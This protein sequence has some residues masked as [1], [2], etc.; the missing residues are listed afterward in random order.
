M[1]T[2][3]IENKGELYVLTNLC[4]DAFGQRVSSEL[5]ISLVDSLVDHKLGSLSTATTT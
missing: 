4:G 1:I 3:V 5:Q 2:N